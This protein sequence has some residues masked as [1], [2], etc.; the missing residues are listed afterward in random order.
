MG[1]LEGGFAGCWSG[2]CCLVRAWEMFTVGTG[3]CSLVRGCPWQEEVPM[4][5]VLCSCWAGL[6][7]HLPLLPLPLCAAPGLLQHLPKEQLEGLNLLSGLTFCR[8]VPCPCGRHSRW[9]P[10]VGIPW[11]PLF[12]LLPGDQVLLQKQGEGHCQ[13]HG[14][15]SSAVPVMTGQ[16][17]APL[18][19]SVAPSAAVSCWERLEV[20]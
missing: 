19:C 16:V 13:P 10:A 7:Q 11:S 17:A 1:R 8:G 18:R 3:G 4:G 15:G 2:R 20:G 12:G 9:E 5:G 14:G 6:E